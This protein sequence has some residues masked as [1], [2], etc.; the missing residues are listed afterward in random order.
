[1]IGTTISHYKIL[2]RIGA[3]GMSVVYKAEDTRLGRLVALKFLP[4]GLEAGDEEKQ[5]F[6]IEARAASSL[7]HPNICTIYEI[8]ETEHGQMFIVLAYYPGDTLKARIE[9]GPLEIREI[10]QIALQIAGGLAKAHA[11]GIVHRDIKPANIIITSQA[12]AKILDFGL[13]KLAGGSRITRSRATLGTLAYMS[14]EQARGEEVDPR[15][16]IW[17]VGVLLYEMITG[18][19]PFPADSELALVYAINNEDP[20]PVTKL[21]P[22]ADRRLDAVIN[23]CLEKE[24]SRRYQT[25]Q[26][27]CEDL[28]LCLGSD[29]SPAARRALHAPRRRWRRR[30]HRHTLRWGLGAAASLLVILSLLVLP[31]LRSSGDEAAP[32]SARVFAVFPFTVQGDE[33]FAYLE[34]G[35]LDLLYTNLDRAGGLRAVD[36]RSLLN[37]IRLLHKDKLELADAAAIARFF[38]ARHYLMGG[39][40]ATGGQL[41]FSASLYDAGSAARAPVPV[42][43]EGGAEELLELVDR[44]TTTIVANYSDQPADGLDLLGARTTRSLPALKAYLEGRRLDRLGRVE[45]AWEFYAHATEWDSTFAMAWYHLCYIDAG[46]IFNQERA[47]RE[48]RMAQRHSVRLSPHDRLSLDYWQNVFDGEN[49]KALQIGEQMVTENPDDA[50]G[51]SIY[52]GQWWQVSVLYGHSIT[53]KPEADRRML[54]LDPENAGNYHQALFP[55]LCRGNLEEIDTL[56]ARLHRYGPDFPFTWSVEIPRAFMNGDTLLRRRLMAQATSQSELCQILGIENIH[57]QCRDVAEAIPYARFLIDPRR[58]TWLQAHGWLTLATMEMSCGRWRAAMSKLDTL[59]RFL[60]EY[61]PALRGLFYPLYGYFAADSAR[62]IQLLQVRSWQPRPRPEP[63][64]MEWDFVPMNAILPFIRL[65]HLGMLA[66]FSGDS[67]PAAKYAEQLLRAAAQRTEQR[68]AAAHGAEPRRPEA[69]PPE[70]KSLLRLWAVTIQALAAI[71]SGREAEALRLLENEPVIIRYPLFSSP[72]YSIPFTRFLRADLLARNGRYEEALSWLRAFKG[73]YVYDVPWRAPA[74]LRMGEILEKM[75]RP[76]EAAQ[77]YKKFLFM[78]RD[79][80]PEFR[81]LTTLAQHR[82]ARL[83]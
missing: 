21:R 78:W 72:A 8:S 11:Q 1:M 5:R 13:A 15:A 59:A 44:M 40:I 14:P 56:L 33:E 9:K 3:G 39:L 71:K 16:D 77:E 75:E 57:V 7:D 54:E 6:V 43:T 61:A 28:E 55:A 53:E 10:L 47:E 76:D 22:E 58:S 79:C 83:Q 27:L 66:H 24:P 67:L 38:G 34:E 60:P 64:G 2:E 48:L 52:A 19:L 32:L 49:S 81:H 41:R 12:V 31:R 4:P 69:P 45:E 20:E 35:M 30:R 50:L 36:P 51:W 23:H 62:S 68:R 42:T 74:A 65:Y 26:E 37:R 63:F 70:A 73:L 82:L 80:D 46:W 29:S 25:M 17:S 18:R